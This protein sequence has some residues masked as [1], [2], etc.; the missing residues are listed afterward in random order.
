MAVGEHPL[1]SSHSTCT[2]VFSRTTCTSCDFPYG[3]CYKKHLLDAKPLWS[4]M[5]LF[6]YLGLVWESRFF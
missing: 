2:T 3:K 4:H 5:L 1:G 6:D